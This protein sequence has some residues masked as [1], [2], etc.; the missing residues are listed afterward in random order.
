MTFH[1]Q[2]FTGS[3]KSYGSHLFAGANSTTSRNTSMTG[4][5][6]T[7][8]NVCL[9]DVT[10]TKFLSVWID[11]RLTLNHHLSKLYV[12]LKRNLN[13]LRLGQSLM[14]THAKKCVYYVQVYSHI[15]YGIILWG[16]M[17]KNAK[18]NK[19]QK[20]QNKCFKLSTSQESNVQNFHKFKMLCINEIIRL[21]NAKNSHKVQH[22]HL[23]KWV[24]DCSKSDSTTASLEKKHQYNTY[25]KSS[26]Y[27]PATKSNLYRSSF[28]YK[29]IIEYEK[30]PLK[31]KSIQN[32]TLF[33]H[34][35]L[36]LYLMND[37]YS[38]LCPFAPSIW[39]KL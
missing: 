1:P 14:N 37:H 24:L 9:P 15:S 17:I 33:C 3:N 34:S 28:L 8:N 32:T 39:V 10:Y 29:S 36:Y 16:N 21:A 5:N 4:C 38:N 22:S 27:L 25:N 19:L 13:L 7:V 26:L 2:K 6:I 23:P 35:Y 30:V 18:I 31:L 11:N 20:I 12:K